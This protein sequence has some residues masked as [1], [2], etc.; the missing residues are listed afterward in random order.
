MKSIVGILALAALGFAAQ[1][2]S[3]ADAFAYG[4][5]YLLSRALPT[6]GDGILRIDPVSGATS[7]LVDLPNPVQPTF[8]YDAFRDRLLFVDN[9]IGLRTADAAGALGAIPT[10]V[11]PPQQVAARGDGIVYLWFGPGAAATAG[12][13]Y[14]DAAN[15]VHDLLN[16]GG[17]ARQTFTSSF[18][19]MLYDPGTNSLLAF[20]G[21][22]FGPCATAGQT[23]AVRIP[24][25]AG[26]TQVSGALLSAQVE[27]SASELVTGASRGPGGSILVAVDTNTNDR[28]N[29]VQRLDPAAM[30]FSV[31]AANGPYT[32]AAT[33]STGAWDANIARALILDTF[34][35][36]LR[37]FASGEVGNGT[38]FA[39][40]VSGSGHSEDARLLQIVG[41]PA[42]VPA[43][44]RWGAAAL[45]SA[46]AA[47]AALAKFRIPGI[48]RA[49]GRSR[50]G[51][52]PTA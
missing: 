41:A 16:A 28:E 34:N 1:P 14:L 36:V 27:V 37:S 39:T 18:Q 29:R 43:L 13:A 15:V 50:R 30:S 45:A 31:F 9:V 47:I 23:C 5:V 8:S 20:S 4:D 46:L 2:P 11:L 6:A 3:A 40:G 17:T 21:V 12:L 49:G 24:L 33:V 32:G 38:T 48:G 51:S 35:D 25:N 19:E 10:P 44:P 52:G 7:L 22:A 42:A 26:G